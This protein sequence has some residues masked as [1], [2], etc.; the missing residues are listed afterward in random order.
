MKAFLGLGLLLTATSMAVAGQLNTVA[1]SGERVATQGSDYPAGGTREGL[2]GVYGVTGTPSWDVLND[3]D[4]I[5]VNF[6]LAAAV[7]FASGTPVAM[8]GVGWDVTLT[9]LGTSWQSELAVGF[10]AA[11]DIAPDVFLSPG[12]GVNTPGTGVFTSGGVVK[13]GDVGIPDI[14]LPTGV[15]RMEFHEG[16]DDVADAIDGL[17]EQ[18]ILQ[19]QVV[20]EPASLGLLVLGGLMAFRRR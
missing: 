17:W 11:G 12:A 2:V 1:S 18:G 19:L 6:D 7:G 4:N 8:N 14:I 16:F 10:S 15:L 20:P 3:G 13:L 5:V 9:A